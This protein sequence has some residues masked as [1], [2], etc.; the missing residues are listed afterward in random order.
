MVA[1]QVGAWVWVALTASS[2]LLVQYF[3]KPRLPTYSLQ[4]QSLPWIEW[5]LGEGMFTRLLTRV[6]LRNENFVQIDVHGLVFDMFY[7]NWDGELKHVGLVQ[8]R[9]LVRVDTSA[10]SPSSFSWW[11]SPK[12]IWQIPP[13]ADF[14]STAELYIAC[15]LSRFY[16]TITRLVWSIW[17]GGGSLILPTTGVAFIKA[18]S[19]MPLTVSIVCDNRFDT[20]T[21]QVQGVECVL[22]Q[23]NPGWSM[24]AIDSL[25][26]HALSN[27]RANS[28]GGVLEHPLSRWNRDEVLRQI[29]V[30]EALQL[31]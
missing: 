19:Q 21:L 15:F 14:T 3:S 4:I 23:L 13:R 7:M 29:A 17:V 28:T 26:D 5:I 31:P 9:H 11:K 6:D 12:P 20:W 22:H 25:R 2:G 27:L 1:F 24:A 16:G 8:D 30:E 10:S 18:N